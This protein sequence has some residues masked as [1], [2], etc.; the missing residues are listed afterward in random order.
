M[1]PHV[2]LIKDGNESFYRE[3]GEHVLDHKDMDGK[4]PFQYSAKA[5]LHS[6]N[7]LSDKIE[8]IHGVNSIIQ[9]YYQACII[10]FCLFGSEI[11]VTV[12]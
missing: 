12:Y 3:E 1:Q 11:T 4:T 7:V 9:F 2:V 6:V 5:S 10:S 8:V